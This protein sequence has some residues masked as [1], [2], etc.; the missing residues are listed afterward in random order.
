M[1]VGSGTTISRRAGL[2]VYLAGALALGAVV[3]GGTMAAHATETLKLKKVV[4]I[5]GSKITS[6]DISFVDSVTGFYVLGDRTNKGV[7]VIDTATNTL[8]F[9]AGQGAFRGVQASN[10]ISG[11]DGVMIVNRREIWAGDGDSTLKF[12]SLFNGAVLGAVSTGGKFRV[13]EMC[14]DPVHNIGFVANN[15]DDPPF[16]TAVSA[17]THSIL[18]KIV[19]DG[20]NGTPHA[21]NG[22]EQCA[23][24]PRDGMI[25]VTVPDIDRPAD[26][27]E[28]NSVPGGVS[29]IDPLTR[30]VT[31]TFVIPLEFCSGPQ[32]LA[33]GPLVG[34]LSG[35]SNY[36]EMLTGCNG[37]VSNAAANRPT[38][39]ID[40][41][42]VSG[43]FGN[44]IGLNFQAGNDEIWFNSG[45]NHY[46]LARSGN[47]SFVNP[48]PNPIPLG[49]PAT[50][51]AIN[52]GANIYVSADTLGMAFGNSPDNALAGPQVVGMINALTLENDPDT[53]TGLA[54]C[55]AGSPGPGRVGITTAANANPHGANHSVAADS[56]HNQVYV[57]IASTAVATGMTGICG[58]AGFGGSDVNG[59]IAVFSIVGTDP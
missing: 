42:S 55:P 3:V 19:F 35:F 29:R 24:N 6:F 41:G 14:F 2:A 43:V 59:C 11:P 39:L 46:Y 26:N 1:N 48:N 25:Y 8:Q 50:P 52:Y 45:D 37:A 4:S 15:A 44:P 10:D 12:L 33:I 54:N 18:G 27:H 28:P 49:C 31:A 53:I 21:T 36:G 30:T 13:D 22:I 17:R 9:I 56:A 58:T 40:D 57:P 16:I 32:G 20:T 34:S 5:P 23:F 38:A 47:N 51:G 7:D